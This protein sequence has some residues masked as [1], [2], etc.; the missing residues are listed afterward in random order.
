MILELVNFRCWRKHVFEFPDSGL[1]LLSGH[2][3]IGKSTI[4]NAIYFALY[5]QGTKVISFGERKCSV[6]F[7]FRGFDITRTKGPN[8]LIVVYQ[9]Q[10]YEDQVAQDIIDT[11]FGTHFPLT[12]YITQKMIDSFLGLTPS[13]K[14]EFLEKLMMSQ[15]DISTLKDKVRTQIH[16]SKETLSKISG[17]RE[18]WEQEFMVLQ[19]PVPIPFPFRKT[20]SEQCIKNH[21]IRWGNAKKRMKKCDK[22]IVALQQEW[23][24]DRIIREKHMALSSQ[25]HKQETQINDISTELHAHPFHEKE[26]EWMQLY[27]DVRAYESQLHH[28]QDESQTT[29]TSLDRLVREEQARK[30]ETLKQ[31]SIKEQTYQKKLAQL[32]EIT[33]D[34]ID[35]YNVLLEYMKVSAH[36]KTTEET[37]HRETQLV[38]T[39]TE[40][41]T[42]RVKQE[43]EEIQSQLSTFSL[44]TLTKQIQEEDTK[45]KKWESALT[46]L[47]RLLH[48]YSTHEI[49]C[50]EEETT[51]L[52]NQESEIQK[53][54]DQIT[55]LTNQI[56]VLTQRKQVLCCPNCSVSLRL[57][58]NQ[59]IQE[60]LSPV[61]DEE[62]DRQIHDLTTQLQT[63]T[64]SL[65]SL[66]TSHSN[67]KHVIEQI[68][69]LIHELD[70]YHIIPDPISPSIPFSQLVQWKTQWVQHEQAVSVSLDEHREQK[71]TYLALK[72]QEQKL[73]QEIKSPTLSPFLLGKQKEILR[74]GKEVASQKKI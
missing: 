9:N 68:N 32:P 57:V 18:T 5:G 74:L 63:Y 13:G 59:L 60:S 49:E 52:L 50:L 53:N 37:L 47:S 4:L 30:Q 28:L 51:S 56:R 45:K 72:K 36:L 17:K 12:S 22:S 73:Q 39:L 14:M 69:V 21:E 64:Q 26:W 65:A 23:T 55:S 6:H 43:H 3:G 71:N 61:S 46:C 70:S 20:Y 66:Q 25:L 29:Q 2:S 41:E 11:H 15:D 27:K 33:Q 24:Q 34:D 8:R 19:P 58:Q 42:S 40:Q 44:S 54:Q 35:N 1:I 62:A 48:I 10:A 67:L 7:V 31:V 16:T 38:S